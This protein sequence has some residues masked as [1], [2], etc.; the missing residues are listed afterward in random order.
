MSRLKALSTVGLAVAIALSGCGQ[1]METDE[2]VKVVL[3][4]D[5]SAAAAASA[6]LVEAGDEIADRLIS[7]LRDE[8]LRSK[9]LRIVKIFQAM[10][11]AGTLK[12]FKIN[13]VAGV[14]G[15]VLRDKGTAE[16]TKLEI[17]Q[18]LAN[19]KAP[20]AVRPLIAVLDSESEALRGASMASLTQLGAIA[21][22]PLVGIRDDA[23]TSSDKRESV[24]R[25]LEKVAE[26]LAE[27]LASEDAAERQKIVQLLGKIGSEATRGF[28]TQASVVE[29]E[30]AKVRAGIVAAIAAEPTEAEREVLAKLAGDKDQAVAIEAIA[31]LGTAKAS[32]AA[33]H[34]ASVIAFS[35]DDST[36]FAEAKHRI[37]A[38]EAMPILGDPEVIPALGAVLL[39][40]REIKVRR[41]AALALESFGDK[42]DR[43]AMLSAMTT[44]ELDDKVR[45]ICAR[46]LGK[47]G[48][49][50]GVQELV[51]L[52]DSKDSTVRIPAIKALGQVGEPAVSALV[53]CLRDPGASPAR[54]ASACEALGTIGSREAVDAL[55]TFIRRPVP[56]T[57]ARTAD[58]ETA[59]KDLFVR[60]AEPH[61]AAIQA[62]SRIGDPKGIRPVCDLL[63]SESGRLRS[64]AE[65]S[66][67]QFRAKASDEL[68]DELVVRLTRP[69]SWLLKPGDLIGLAGIAEKVGNPDDP[70]AAMLR[71]E[72]SESTQQAL[73]GAKK[74][75]EAEE[76]DE[77]AQQAKEAQ[78]DQL[79]KALADELNGLL[80]SGA[81]YNRD[82]F[83]NVW[84]PR[85][86]EALADRG[87]EGDDLLRL[88]RALL[89]CAFSDEI[90][91]HSHPVTAGSLARILGGAGGTK[92]QEILAAL[93]LLLDEQTI[94]FQ[95]EVSIDVV[96][97]MANLVKE[98]AR[99]T[100]EAR[101]RLAKLAEQSPGLE[102]LAQENG[103][104]GACVD[105]LGYLR[106][107]RSLPVLVRLLTSEHD[108]RL[109]F[110]ITA[111]VDR[112]IDNAEA[113]QGHAASELELLAKVVEGDE[114]LTRGIDSLNSI[115]RQ[116]VL[117]LGEMKDLRAVPAIVKVLKG[118]GPGP[119]LY[120]AA[121]LAYL[122]ITGRRYEAGE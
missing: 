95:P 58:E 40:D 29:D 37:R 98:G 41:A 59:A 101:A 104:R 16:E 11:E 44:K 118:T 54:Q 9:H 49:Q 6:K 5:E 79:R 106:D 97:S 33:R 85:Q 99:P 56:E 27:K 46:A 72:L 47:M 105:V 68:V 18:A 65:W 82:Q 63:A 51:G 107:P 83:V 22:E 69:D 114:E 93:A 120:D 24:A 34:L 102:D 109:R 115:Q 71:G 78:D 20:T 121:S 19:F 39:K 31:A 73:R 66:L 61:T 112:L 80:R 52:L 116:A 108:E 3:S 74:A 81:L 25:A 36:G 62:L 30:D 23:G 7:I 26:S 94:L 92:V 28:V 70:F 76:T 91:P 75:A 2:L 86:L 103:L 8:H 60:G 100:E 57:R 84:V 90:R 43:Q 35:G 14:L 48:V 64:F 12:D 13:K 21:V 17:A 45:L 113:E 110:R 88:N 89:W 77:K 4:D 87:L 32:G 96:A 50:D 38:I 55:I 15:D 117:R 10:Q 119:E 53:A 67:N 111:S 1:K 42:G 122:R